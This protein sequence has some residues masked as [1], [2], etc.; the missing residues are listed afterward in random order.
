MENSKSASLKAKSQ[1]A[2]FINKVYGHL[3]IAALLLK[4]QLGL[5]FDIG[6][7]SLAGLSILYD[8]SN[9]IK[10]YRS[11]KYVSNTLSL[12]ASIALMFWYAVRIFRPIG[13]P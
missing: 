2:V 1:K 6:I 5:W 10:Y 8:T 12:F 3:L 11:N 4:F 9:I 7:V 13:R